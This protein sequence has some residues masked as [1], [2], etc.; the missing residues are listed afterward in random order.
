M[1]VTLALALHL[2]AIV[3]WIGGLSFVTL[4]VLPLARSR[5]NAA[6]GVTFFEAVEARF[7]AQVRLSI[8]LAGATGLWMT[9]RLDL[10]AR[11]ADPHFWWMAAMAGLWSIF[12]LMVFTLEPLLRGKLSAQ[13]RREPASLI[14]RVARLHMVLLMLSLLTVLGAAAGAHG[15]YFF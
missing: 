15:Y 4:I 12:A 9:Y 14:R 13:A 2:V 3:H 1:D 5:S 8:P 11:F 10:W 6:E 7:A